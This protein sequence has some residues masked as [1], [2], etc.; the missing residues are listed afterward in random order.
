MRNARSSV[1]EAP[2]RS[3][4]PARVWACVTND[5][6]AGESLISRGG[7]AGRGAAGGN[8]GGGESGEDSGR[9]ETSGLGEVRD[10]VAQPASSKTLSGA[11][12]PLSERY[13]RTMI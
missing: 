6:V 4:R 7:G 12:R 2:S 5:C 10:E 13:F 9:A 11:M 1:D 3:P 8:A